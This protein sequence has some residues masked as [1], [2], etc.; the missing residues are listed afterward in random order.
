MLVRKE[1]SSIRSRTLSK[2]LISCRDISCR[3]D[4][5]DNNDNDLK[6]VIN[7]NDN[8]ISIQFRIPSD[9]IE[10]YYYLSLRCSSSDI[11]SFNDNKD[12]FINNKLYSINSSSIDLNSV[13]IIKS[14]LLKKTSEVMDTGD[15]IV[16]DDS[17]SLSHRIEFSVL[18][19]IS[20]IFEIYDNN[21]DHNCSSNIRQTNNRILMCCYRR[22]H[23]MIDRTTD[24]A[25]KR[26]IPIIEC[27]SNE[28]HTSRINDHHRYNNVYDD[29]DNNN[30]NNNSNNNNNIY[31]V[32][33]SVEELPRYQIALVNMDKELTK[34]KQEVL[35]FQKQSII[36]KRSADLLT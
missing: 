1:T 3:N 14:I 26:F 31:Q 22:F 24:N 35:S 7:L 15:D 12:Q 36:E 8:T 23:A 19:I 34:L 2:H 9:C 29:T 16:D 18:P 25:D 10:G 32:N 27:S 20:D 28:K 21:N 33:N 5:D 17:I 13:I 6:F 4:D 30:D 11:L